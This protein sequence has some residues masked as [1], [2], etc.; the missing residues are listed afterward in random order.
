MPVIA[1]VP[2]PIPDPGEVTRLLNEIKNGNPQA[3]DYYQ[4]MAQNGVIQFKQDLFAPNTKL[5]IPIGNTGMALPLAISWA[6]RTE[7]IKANEVR[8]QFGITFDLAQLLRK[9]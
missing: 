3:A 6:N 9:K 8:G 7:L 4:Y 2:D 5:T 1:P